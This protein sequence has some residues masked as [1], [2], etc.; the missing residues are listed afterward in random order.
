MDPQARIF[1]ECIWSALEDS[2]YCPT[3]YEGLIGLYAGAMYNFEWE[4]RVRLSGKADE[5]GGFAS[6]LLTNK[7]FLSTWI[8]YKLN[9]KGPAVVV[10][11]ACSTSLAAIHLACRALV[12]GECDLALAGVCQSLFMKNP[13][14]CTRKV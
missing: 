9:L 1:H 3:R 10:Q 12:D 7:D 6:F 14:I 5:L 13:D 2:G 11:T 8:S 4:A